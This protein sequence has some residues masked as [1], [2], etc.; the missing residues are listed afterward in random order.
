M[1]KRYPIAAATGALCLALAAACAG[2]GPVNLAQAPTG[3]PTATPTGSPG[4]PTGGGGAATVPGGF[5]LVGS[6]ANGLA[7]AVPD[8]WVAL[9]LTKD[10]LQ[11]GLKRS[12]LSGKALERAQRDLQ[13]LVTNKAVWAFDPGSRHRSPN[14]FTTNLNGYCQPSSDAS[15]DQLISAATGELQQIRAKIIEATKVP[16]GGTE[17]ARM[18]YVFPAGGMQVKGTQFYLPAQGRTCTVTLSTDQDG[19]QA[20]F[21]RIGRTIRL[22]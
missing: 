22:L 18:V 11:Q 9:D 8:S 5:E 4:H 21:D 13:P 6:T 3:T 12:G 20:L 10:D 15:T 17:A 14:G 2:G 7:V 19:K 1:R 16:V